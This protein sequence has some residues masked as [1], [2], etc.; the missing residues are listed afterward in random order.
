MENPHMQKL[1]NQAKD[2][3]QFKAGVPIEKER[4]GFVKTSFT[5]EC[6][7][8]QNGGLRKKYMH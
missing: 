2:F 4:S 1:V 3:I 8:S 5:S 7:Q 6:F